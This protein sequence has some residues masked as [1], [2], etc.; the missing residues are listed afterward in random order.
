MKNRTEISIDLNSFYHQYTFS[1]N[2]SFRTGAGPSDTRLLQ[3]LGNKANNFNETEFVIGS[4][5]L[6]L[7]NWL[8][9]GI[10]WI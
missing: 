9:N 8:C 5:M 4:V 7:K 10:I 6:I 2:G 3:Y 1:I